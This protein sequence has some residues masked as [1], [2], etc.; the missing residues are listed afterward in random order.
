[1][2]TP[3]KKRDY[4]E[5]LCEICI[6]AQNGKKFA[7]ILPFEGFAQTTAIVSGNLFARVAALGRKKFTLCFFP[8]CCY[9]RYARYGP[10]RDGPPPRPL[11]NND[12]ATPSLRGP[13]SLSWRGCGGGPKKQ[14]NPTSKKRTGKTLSRS[15]ALFC[16]GFRRAI[17]VPAN[18]MYWHWELRH[19]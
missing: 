6:S 13:P 19:V 5:I 18:L 1:M 3:S 15:R 11:R 2:G 9:G 10:L 8:Y 17:L 7:I 4:R 14:W 16:P 12:R